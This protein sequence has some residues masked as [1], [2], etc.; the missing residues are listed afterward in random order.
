MTTSEALSYTAA[1][2]EQARIDFEPYKYQEE[3]LERELKNDKPDKPKVYRSTALQT[4]KRLDDKWAEYN[5]A[6]KWATLESTLESARSQIEAADKEYE[7]LSSGSDSDETAK[8]EALYE[9]AQS[10]LAAA[11]AALADV[12]LRAPFKGT[13]AGLNIK[14][15]ES[16]IPGEI[17]VSVADF[18]EWIV[19]TTDLTELDVVEIS[20]GQTVLIKLDAIP[21]MEIEG[22]V[23]EI[24]QNYTEKQGDIVYKV[25]VELIDTLPNMRWGMTVTVKFTGE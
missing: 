11:E 25:T 10:H 3:R 5:K 16:I 17:A 13:I 7:K 22:L 15:G 21:D 12:E 6:I 9:A 18:S 8:A 4:K 1:N 24:G 14:P 2:L 23:I 20:D 19:I